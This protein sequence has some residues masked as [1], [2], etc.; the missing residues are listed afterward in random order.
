MES[1][2]NSYSLS[3]SF[4]KYPDVHTTTHSG[5]SA[6]FTLLLSLSQN[7]WPLS[8]VKVCSRFLPPGEF[9]LATVA[10]SFLWRDQLIFPLI[11]HSALRCL[12]MWFSTKA[13]TGSDMRTCA[14]PYLQTAQRQQLCTSQN[15]W[16][17]KKGW[18]LSQIKKPEKLICKTLSRLVASTWYIRTVTT[19]WSHI[20]A[21][22]KSLLALTKVDVS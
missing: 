2:I 20:R 22:D 21:I 8:R 17:G 15:P 7:R 13:D 6:T 9:F 5:L 16:Q 11:V 3:D 12:C 19:K 10:L 14:V 1:L 18:C 4:K